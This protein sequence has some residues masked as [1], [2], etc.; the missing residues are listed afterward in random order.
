[1]IRFIIGPLPAWAERENPLLNYQL[2]QTETPSRGSRLLRALLIVLLLAGLGVGG[3][4]VATNVFAQPAGQHA[5]DIAISVLFYPMLV[6]QIGLSLAALALTIGTVSE[7]R[8]HLTWENLR[9]TPSGA[10]LTLRTRWASVFYRLRA[11]LGLVV[12]IRLL[13]IG[14]M[15]LDLTAFQGRYLDLL[16][17]GV[18]PSLPTMLGPVPFA[19]PLAA[20]LLA[21][22]LTAT[23][24]LPF[25]DVAFNAALGILLST[26]ISRRI[27]SVVLQFLL[28][29]V[30]VAVVA[31]LVWLV[32][33]FIEGRSPFPLED[34]QAWLSVFGFSAFA[35]WGLMLLHLGFSGEVWTLIP[36]GLFI[37][38]ML[39]VYMLLQA[40]LANFLLRWAVRLGQRRG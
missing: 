23:L 32:M 8:G 14:G 40:A 38:P 33:G 27:Y 16:I 17:S 31:A 39:V 22:F 24:L 13:L 3:W 28:F 30:R 35:D 5:T 10:A 4:A 9:A 37:G 6:V 2:K 26:L 19:V 11:A 1:M 12:L 34:W 29:I 7:E 36:Y 21:L 25:T 18:E 20:L 15:L